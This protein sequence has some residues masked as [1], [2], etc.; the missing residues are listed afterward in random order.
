MLRT[1]LKFNPDWDELASVRAQ[2][3]TLFIDGIVGK[4]GEKKIYKILHKTVTNLFSILSIDI[5]F[6]NV[7]RNVNRNGNKNVNRSFEMF[8]YA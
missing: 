3:D 8:F 1:T 4:K 6:Q 2:L 5:F 7:N